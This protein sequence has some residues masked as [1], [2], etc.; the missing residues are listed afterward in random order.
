MIEASVLLSQAVDKTNTDWPTTLLAI[1]TFALVCA[2]YLMAQ[3]AK[4]QF[5]RQ[6][7]PILIPSRI[8][9]PIRKVYFS[10][11]TWQ[12]LYG[13]QVLVDSVDTLYVAI[14]LRNIGSGT[15]VVRGL[16]IPDVGPDDDALPRRRPSLKNLIAAKTDLLL[17]PGDISHLSID[18][19]A[20]TA[21]RQRHALQTQVER[22]DRD[23]GVYLDI[24]HCDHVR[25]QHN[26]TRIELAQV[27]EKSSSSGTTSGAEH[28][29]R[30][31]KHWPL[32]RRPRW[33]PSILKR[34]WQR[35]IER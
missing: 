21:D 29:A 10:N 30:A 6:L 5:G 14:P 25:R 9:D 34:D 35:Q 15:A 24:L 8:R 27:S 19:E 4:R 18:S 2:T 11:N 31:V 22:I 16:S 28:I 7:L 33:L 26:I 23:S 20:Q 3:T 1:V 13:D 32:R 12:M 17:G